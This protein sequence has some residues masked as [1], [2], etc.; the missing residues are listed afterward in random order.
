MIMTNKPGFPKKK[1]HIIYADP[2]WA[3]E[4][5]H[6]PEGM[7]K[8]G[9]AADVYPVM[10]LEDIMALNVKSITDR[11]YG[12]LFLWTTGPQ[13]QNSIDL[14]EMWGFE[15]RTV[16]FV[17]LKT[18]RKVSESDPWFVPED[19]VKVFGQWTMSACEF[20]LVGK[21]KGAKLDRRSSEVRQVVVAPRGEHSAKPV[22][23]AHRIVDLCGDVPR[24]ELFARCRMKGWDA[25][26]LEVD[27]RL[28]LD[29]PKQKGFGF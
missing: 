2:P 7:P 21:C 5:R 29:G 15:Y 10:E 18:G 13:L 19:F 16:A 12:K 1:Y 14:M 6:A 24:I 23:V 17:W 4:K 22:E 26:G 9:C 25:W 11:C 27:E 20:V 3:Y 8:C 28:V